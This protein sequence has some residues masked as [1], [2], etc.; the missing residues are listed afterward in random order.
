MNG[1]FMI[2]DD[3]PVEING[4]KNILELVRKAGIDLPTFCYYSELSVYGA[5]RMCMVENKWG[6]MEASCSTPPRAGMEIHTNTPRLRKYRKMNLELLLSNHCRD[7]TTCEKNGHC[8]LQD[9]SQRFGIKQVRFNNTSEERQIDNS[10]ACIVRDKSKCIL[11]GDC[12]RVCEEVQNIGAIDFVKRGSK[13]TVTTA[14]DEPIA[15]SNCVGCGQCAAVCP[16]GAIVVKN[17]T[18]RLWE[19][20]SDKD[21]KVV[22]QIAPAV[23]VGISQELGQKDGENVMGKIVSSLR[24]MGFDEV[25]DT[26]TGADLTVLEETT[27]FLSRL[28]KN[29][30]LPLFTSCC[31]AWVSYVENTYPS[32]MKNVST[33]RSPM[34]MFSSVLKEHYKHSNKRVVSV[35]IMPCTAKKSEAKRDEFTENGVS[36]VD[37]VITTRELIQMIKE[38][39]IVFSE[40]EPEAV[41]MPFGVSSGAGVIFGVTGGVTEAVI[42]RVLDDKSTSTLRA[43]AF[44]GVRGMAGVKETSITVDNRVINI[45]VVSGLKNADEL[46]KRIQSGAAHYDFIEVMACP[47]GCIS[48]AGQPFAKAEGKLK[49]GA[50]LYE[51]DRM[52]SIKRSEENPVMMSLYQGLL[53]GKVHKLLHVDYKGKE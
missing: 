23:R 34:Q 52:S 16:T 40:V 8:K 53:K 51:A 19:D 42:R 4:E 36:S 33:C 25:F 43:L 28:E 13:M 45:A 31:P 21:T 26:S 46:I 35:A 39:G 1:E 18:A 37:Y 30:K 38:S 10:S 14:F 49:R 48:G 24:K 9:L 20:I 44:N 41:D 27:E 17:D 12:V 2:I 3:I 22:V 15:D 7:C 6:D 50:G 47:G 5:C 11:C 32:L 29:E